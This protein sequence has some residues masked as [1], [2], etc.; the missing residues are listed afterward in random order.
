LDIYAKR[1]P[2]K[3][4]HGGLFEV[5]IAQFNIISGSILDEEAVNL[6]YN[7]DS[8]LL[9]EDN[10][11]FN[12]SNI[13]HLIG[14]ADY[15]LSRFCMGIESK[16]CFPSR[17]Q[18]GPSIKHFYFI[19]IAKSPG[20]LRMH[21]LFIRMLKLVAQELIGAFKMQPHSGIQRVYAWFTVNGVIVR[22]YVQIK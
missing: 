2:R 10:L 7:C 21:N 13:T 6:Y 3:W 20:K 11:L 17:Y 15:K 22:Q 9:D 8:V 16:F 1:L 12:W 18:I 4:K 14:E 5:E 19:K